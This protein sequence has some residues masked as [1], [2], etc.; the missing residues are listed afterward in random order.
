[1]RI[2]KNYLKLFLFRGLVAMGFGPIVLTAIYGTLGICGVV[3]SFSVAEVA[4][5]Y[6]S[7]SAL[8]FV[9]GAMTGVYQIEELGLAQSIAAHFA[10]LYVCYATVYILNGW[11]EEGIIPFVIFTLIFITVYALIWLTIYLINK[12]SANILNSKL[13]NR[14][15]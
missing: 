7:I 2:F 10:V 9:C 6:L 4:L 12:R 5:G 1:M 3:D 13:K 14:E 11:L 15:E 8:A